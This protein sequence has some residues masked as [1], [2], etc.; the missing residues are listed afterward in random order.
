MKIKGQLLLIWLAGSLSSGALAQEPSMALRFK[1]LKNDT[2][3]VELHASERAELGDP[4]FERV[5]KEHANLT[6]LDDVLAKLEPNKD[7][8]LVFVVSEQILDSDPQTGGNRRCVIAFTDPHLRSNVMMSVFFV[9]DKFPSP[10]AGI[11]VWGWDNFRGRYNYYRTD[12][13]ASGHT[14]S[15]RFRGSSVGA[16]Q[17]PVSGPDGRR[18]SC[19]QC[20]INGAPVM[21][22]LFFPWNNWH[23]TSPETKYLTSAANPPWAVVARMASLGQIESAALLETQIVPALNRFNLQRINNALRRDDVTGNRFVGPEGRMEV[24]EGKR[25]LKALFQTTEVNLASANQQSGIPSLGTISPLSRNTRINPP[26][27]FFLNA[28]LIAGGDFAGIRGLQITSARGLGSLLKLTAGENADTLE[29]LKIKLHSEV[30]RDA[31]FAWFVP[32]P[33]QIDNDLIGSCLQ[34]G[35]IS[36]QFLA[37]ALA[38]DIRNPAFSERRAGLLRFV[39]DKFSYKPIPPNEQP[40]NVPYDPLKD[41]L[42]QA[43]K[44]AIQASNPPADSP[45]AEFLELLN[46]DAVAELGN[47]V[48]LLRNDLEKIGALGA[49]TPERY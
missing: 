48:K 35:I 41:E 30:G 8:R 24:M 39:P 47:R 37:A 1:Q 28:N 3:P 9:A 31:N 32:E 14:R 15:W 2:E 46:G 7:K 33:S 38:V 10:P 45:A 36:R 23:T 22:E 29:S 27:S 34:Q 17:V 18:A 49:G 26:D 11:E 5:L 42:L 4:F 40:E 16:D 21:K 12:D 44:A 19:M 25:L 43:V 20:H 6:T 13:D